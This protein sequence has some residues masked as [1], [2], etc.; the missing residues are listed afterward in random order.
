MAAL[1]DTFGDVALGHFARQMAELDPERRR[2]SSAW[3]VDAEPRDRVGVYRLQLALGGAG[4]GRLRRSRSRPASRAVHVAARRRAPARRR[5]RCT[6][7]IR[8]STPPPRVLLAFAALG[9]AVLVV[10]VCAAR[11]GR[12]VRTGGC[13]ARC[14]S[15]GA[16]PGHPAVVVDRRRAPLAFCAG[17]LRP[18][19]YVSTG[20]ARAALGRRAARGARAR[21]A[22]PARCAT[23]C[24]WPSAAC[25]AQ[26]LFFLPV[27]RPLHDRYGE[28]RRAHGRRRRGGRGRRRDRVRWRRRCSRFDATRRAAVVG[29]SPERVDSLLGLPRA[30]RPP[31]LL[32]VAALVTLAA[33]R[34][35]RLARERAAPRSRPR[36]TC[37]SPPRSRACSCSR[38]CRWLAWPCACAPRRARGPRARPSDR[39]EV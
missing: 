2:R 9:A 6:S 28:R 14:P 33:L 7:P 8:R 29:I 34:R 22:A 35:A 38:S 36:S 3:P 1:V 26:A 21:A 24:A 18:R 4:P 37:R 13:C 23:R 20:V 10:A 5:R 30:W 17:W 27:L 15:T 39:A 32:L 31:W 12:C 16:L 11:G 25:S 19:V